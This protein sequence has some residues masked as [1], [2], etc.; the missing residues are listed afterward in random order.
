M[1][2]VTDAPRHPQLMAYGHSLDH[3]PQNQKRR[4]REL[5]RLGATV[6]RCKTGKQG[7]YHCK[8]LVINRRVLYTGSANLTGNSRRNSETVFRMTGPVVEQ[9]LRQLA[10]DRGLWSV[11]GG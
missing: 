8:A 5:L 10:A 9:V 3:H 11:W 2:G 7:S 6:Y 1:V 4:V